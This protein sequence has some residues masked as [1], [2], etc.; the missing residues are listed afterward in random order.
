MAEDR[1]IYMAN[2]IAGFFSAQGEAR[3]VP[4]IANH[5]QRYWEPRMR[6]ALLAAPEEKRA[7]LNPLV[8]KAL[9]LIKV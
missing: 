9:P 3:A 4:A 5:I 1:L 8:A 7:G 2:Q 6:T